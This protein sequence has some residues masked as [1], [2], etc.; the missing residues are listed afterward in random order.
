MCDDGRDDDGPG[1]DGPDDDGPVGGDDGL[2]DDG[3]GDDGRGDDGRDDGC[4]AA[5]PQTNPVF[6]KH[7]PFSCMTSVS[8]SLV[9]GHFGHF[10]HFA[11][12]PTKCPKMTQ[13]D[14]K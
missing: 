12:S 10:G 6:S 8:F 11:H 2:G 7:H 9:C 3:R 14:P 5:G 4:G 1:D 13:N